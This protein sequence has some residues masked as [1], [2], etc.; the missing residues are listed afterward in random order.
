MYLDSARVRRSVDCFT[1]FLC[2][3]PL[4]WT[5]SSRIDTVSAR[6]F[7]S[8]RH[9]LIVGLRE[10]RFLSSGT[11]VLIRFRIELF[12][13]S[14][15]VWSRPQMH[16]PTCKMA[17]NRNDAARNCEFE[18]R[19][20]ESATVRNDTR[21]MFESMGCGA[22]VNLLLNVQNAR[23]RCKHAQQRSAKWNLK[24]KT[25]FFLVLFLSINFWRA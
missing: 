13:T 8:W 23:P 6:S 25:G 22:S 9:N 17:V 16:E 4:K 11:L 5:R 12:T 1:V 7:S 14:C 3:L 18:Y 24:D 20:V 10:R 19:Q 15:Y 2:F 21:K